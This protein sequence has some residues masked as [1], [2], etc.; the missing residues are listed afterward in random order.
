LQLFIS[1]DQADEELLE[2]LVVHLASLQNEGLISPWS[3][4]MI[5][6]GADREQAV[7]EQLEAADIVLLLISADFLASN[8]CYEH[9]MN[10]ALERH[11]AGT[12]HVVPLILRPSDWIGSR[13][14]AL[15]ALPANG[16]P[17]TSWR[18]L[19]EAFAEVAQGIRRMVVQL[20][21]EPRPA[22]QHDLPALPAPPTKLES[23]AVYLES[24]AMPVD[25]PFYI[26]RTAD[27]H[28]TSQLLSQ[29]P[30]LALRGDRQ[31]GKSSLLVRL[32]HQARARG[33]RSCYLNFQNLDAA[34]FDSSEELF[35]GLARMTVDE[36]GS[37]ADPDDAWSTR[38]GAKANWTRFMRRQV[39]DPTV[40]ML[41]LFDEVDL[42]FDFENCR[43]DFFS[44]LRVWHNKRAEDLQGTWRRL[45][46]VIAHT[47]DP[48]QWLD[49]VTESPF[50]VGLR[51]ELED[52]DA[53]AVAELDK[54]HGLPLGDEARRARFLE[55]VGGHPFTV[56][57]ALYKLV[58][59]A[60]SLDELQRLA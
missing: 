27:T 25:S 31:S 56:R 2:R 34:S 54:R 14:A 11:R 53:A 26:A 45:G 24:G 17:L 38:R 32:R 60:C 58:T 40:P 30:T 15:Q 52:F 1:Y 41:L 16:Q 47:I 37:D 28:A 6:P 59:E 4:R 8:Y 9:E 12:A 29:Q 42:V 33:W 21:A 5:T 43:H 23:P 3:R 20:R 10:R 13:F 48:G 57:K 55:I 36:L 51:L 46:L 22:R 44:M 50:N 18:C 19:D 39:L 49:N 35:R 7:S